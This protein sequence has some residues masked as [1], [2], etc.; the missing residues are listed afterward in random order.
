MRCW[1]LPSPAEN[2]RRPWGHRGAAQ[3]LAQCW[4]WSRGGG[5]R[6][7]QD[8]AHRQPGTVLC[9][10]A[11][12]TCHLGTV[13]PILS[14]ALPQLGWRGTRWQ[15]GAQ[16]EEPGARQCATRPAHP[17][18]TTGEELPQGAGS[19]GNHVSLCVIFYSGNAS[20]EGSLLRDRGE[21]HDKVL[22]A[23]C[24]REG[25]REQPDLPRPPATGPP[26]DHR[27]ARRLPPP[28]HPT[29]SPTASM[30]LLACTSCHTWVLATGTWW[31]HGYPGS[32]DTL[33]PQ[34]PFRAGGSTPRTGAQQSPGSLTEGELL[35][36][37]RVG[38][39]P[40]SAGADPNRS[41]N[42]LPSLA[43]LACPA[44]QNPGST[45]TEVGAAQ[46]LLPALS[47]QTAS[48]NWVS[49]QRSSHSV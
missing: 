37:P 3:S 12:L 42:C 19:R 27:R 29:A 9:R 1:G 17:P 20:G 47:S 15:G 11:S 38:V 32:A 4:A 18:R 23:R 22:Q 44:H 28:L 5:E 31:A 24:S 6:P 25:E 43:A 49:F 13:G 7:G 40:G 2:C 48:S 41:S 16:G 21:N 46:V 30:A 10:S 26:W 14:P 39:G 35:R 45:S 8:G 33:Q 34:H 36:S